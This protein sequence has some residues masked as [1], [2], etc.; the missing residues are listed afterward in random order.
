MAYLLISD[1][2]YWYIY[3]RLEYQDKD[4][5]FHIYLYREN[6]KIN[7]AIRNNYVSDQA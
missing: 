7:F 3:L 2:T 5:D 1:I 6:N 4:K